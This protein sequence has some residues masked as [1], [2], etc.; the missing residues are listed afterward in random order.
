MNTEWNG[1]KATY[2]VGLTNNNYTFDVNT[3]KGTGRD[4]SDATPVDH[5]LDYSLPVAHDNDVNEGLNY[6]SYEESN[7]AFENIENIF[8]GESWYVSDTDRPEAAVRDEDLMDL[9]P[10]A[11]KLSDTDLQSMFTDYY[12]DED[13]SQLE[14][15]AAKCKLTPTEYVL[16]L[17]DDGLDSFE[18]GNPENSSY[19]TDFYG[20]LVSEQWNELEFEQVNYAYDIGDWFADPTDSDDIEIQNIIREPKLV[21]ATDRQGRTVPMASVVMVV[22]SLQGRPCSKLLRVLLDS[23]GSDSMCARHLIPNGARL[24]QIPTRTL[25]NTLAGTY[26]PMGS[27]TMTDMRIPAFDKNRIVKSHSF[28]VFDTQCSYDAILGADF[29]TKV[30]MTLDY[31]NLTIKWLGNEIPMETLNTKDQVAAHVESYL[32]QMELEENGFDV[33]SYAASSILDAKYEKVDI[34]EV[35][36]ENCSHLTPEQQLELRNLLKQHDKLFDGSLGKYPGEPMHIEIEPGAQP[37]YRRPYP[38]PHVHLETFRK[39]LDHLVSLEVLSPVK[40]TEWGLPTF[41]IPKKDGRVRWVSD[42]RELNKVIK[43]TQY[44]LPL[45]NEV[46]RKRKTQCFG[47]RLLPLAPL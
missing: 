20:Q 11:W 3:Y 17:E 5:R 25:M 40:D 22:K 47:R 21:M 43:R 35:I 13:E 44:T 23:G 32:T 19:W 30:G 27:V 4:P 2:E 9:D 10:K 7:P 29:L 42:L 33:D 26:A 45:I 46:L 28:L 41:V 8:I 31:E 15:A 12:Y 16:S 24:D 1:L 36:E 34:D 39:E 37:V 18:K 14:L 38:V 6:Y